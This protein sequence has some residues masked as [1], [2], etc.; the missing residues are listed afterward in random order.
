MGTIRLSSVITLDY[1]TANREK[2]Q[3][4]FCIFLKNFSAVFCTTIY[5]GWSVFH[6]EMQT[7]SGAGQRQSSGADATFGHCGLFLCL[8]PLRFA[9]CPLRR[10][11]PRTNR[12]SRSC[13]RQKPDR[14]TPIRFLSCIPIYIAC[15]Q[16]PLKMPHAGSAPR[17]TAR[18]PAA[19]RHSG[20]CDTRRCPAAGRCRYS[21]PPECSPFSS[22]RTK[23]SLPVLPPAE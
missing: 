15:L 11:R 22:H 5:G 18:S 8:A 23:R 6:H 20:R 12:R 19:H 3:A 16:P 21:P 9:L 13:A 17:R 10:N 7:A 14:H 4:F 1:H 2:L